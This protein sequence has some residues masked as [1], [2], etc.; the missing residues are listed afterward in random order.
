VIIDPAP[1]LSTIITTSAALVAII[2]G[3]LVARFVSLDSDQRGSRK[4]LADAADRLTVARDRARSAWQDVLRWEAGEF[5]GSRSVAKAVVNEG[6]TSADELMRVATW[7]YTPFAAEV[8]GEVSRAREGLSGRIGNPD[9]RWPDFRR[10]HPD[11]PEIRWPRVW[12]IVYDGMA[13]KLAEEEEAR[14][15]AEAGSFKSIATAFALPPFPGRATGPFT[16]SGAIAARRHDELL[17]NH[18]RA[19][20]QVEDYEAEFGRLRLEHAEIVRP[21]ARLWWGITILI[22]F[23]AL[24]VVVPL[25]V[26]AT[27]PHDLAVVRWVFYPFIGSLAALIGY[28][29]VYLV[30][31]TRSKSDQPTASA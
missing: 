18:A 6:V 20:Q 3:L 11:L 27:G 13:M 26:M 12:E 21:D 24:G 31:L 30:Q 23:T 22:V 14:R 2:G 4:V 7:R 10:T 9:I 15:R 28:I 17:A 25:L 16:D 5:F 8:A 19:K 29:V 1:F